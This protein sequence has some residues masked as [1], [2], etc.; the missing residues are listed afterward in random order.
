MSMSGYLTILPAL[1]LIASVWVKKNNVIKIFYD[2][3]FGIILSLIAIII[4]ADIFLYPYWGFH[5]DSSVFL[6]LQKPKESFASA[7]FLEIIAAFSICVIAIFV[8]YMGYM[9]FIRKWLRKIYPDQQKIITSVILLLLAL[10]L[11]IPIRGGFTVSTMNVGKVYFSDNMFDNHAAINPTFNLLYSF[12]KSEDFASQYR[13]MEREKAEYIFKEITSKFPDEEIPKVLRTDRPDIILVILESFSFK[14]TMD[15]V[16][17]P[18]MYRYIQEGIWFENFYAN[19]FRTDRG[20]V[21]IL[22]GYPAQPTAS[23]MKYPQKTQTLPSISKS[24]KKESYDLS[25]YYGGDA[26]FTNMRSYLVGA[27]G[28]SNIVSDKDFP[29]NQRMT[30]WGAPDEFLLNKVYHDI[31]E[32]KKENPYLKI[33]LTLSSHEP[34]D[35]PVNRFDAPF[36]NSVA[37][38]DSCLGDFIEKLRISDRW[39]N[40]LV[41][42]VADHAI[43]SY[44]QGLNNYDS[45][46]YHIPLLW[47]GGAIKEPVV[48]KAY[49]SQKDIASTLLSQLDI[50]SENFIFS[51]DILNPSTPKYAYYSYMNGFSMIDT[52]GI[53][54]FDNNKNNLLFQEGDRGLEEKAKALF[55]RMYLDLGE[56]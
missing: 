45:G 48:V 52:S 20:L 36:L 55:Q 24:L 33:V 11:F 51:N 35:V 15:S 4:T 2:V 16:V 34:F 41:V 50:H 18:N 14:V 13:F 39:E 32:E 9:F 28:I 25:F 54:I 31:I 5:F 12:S 19:S 17:A 23:I 46:R 6:Y 42:F 44:P 8:F 56:R 1:L 26:D 47:I 7:S 3:Y 22:S 53:V 43:Q 29:I 30:K 49:G 27:C 40:T 21:S 38:T 10:F 37:Y